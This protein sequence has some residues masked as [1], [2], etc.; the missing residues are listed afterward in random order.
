MHQSQTFQSKAEQFYQF[1]YDFE[2][3]NFLSYLYNIKKDAE[4]NLSHMKEVFTYYKPV[5]KE[6]SYYAVQN[7]FIGNKND[8]DLPSPHCIN[9]QNYDIKTDEFL[10]LKENLKPNNE[11]SNSHCKI[12]KDGRKKKISFMVHK[13][14]KGMRRKSGKY[15]MCDSRFKE[16]CIEEAK[17]TENLKHVTKKYGV[18]LK[19]LKRWLQ[20]GANRQKGGGRKVLDPNM[21]VKLIN[22]Y[23]SARSHNEAVS[24]R[25]MQNKAKEFTT[26]D[27]FLASKG[28]L[29]K[30]L[31]KYKIYVDKDK[32]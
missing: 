2:E 24:A 8:F 19:K 7:D 27:K 22:W 16:L 1:N 13:L 26:A 14:G 4:E 18:P 5:S 30:F 20:V 10:L 15:N 6:S 11:D 21:E 12:N 25:K 29:E 31:K 23:N 32:Y 3:E 9:N 17:M 28:W